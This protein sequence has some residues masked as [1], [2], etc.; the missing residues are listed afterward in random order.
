LFFSRVRN[1]NIEYPY[2][3][4]SIKM[5]GYRAFSLS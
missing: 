5:A 4:T 3:L 1:S 2:W